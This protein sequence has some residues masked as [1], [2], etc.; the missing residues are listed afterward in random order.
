[1]PS[2]FGDLSVALRAVQ[3]HQVSI[4]TIEHNVSNANTVGYHRQEAVLTA[5][6]AYTPPTLRGQAT[7]GMIGGGV[8]VNNIKRFKME[9]FD[10][11]YRTELASS[12]RWAIR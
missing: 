2:L 11:R 9:F 12:K 6:L 10:N 3:A 4:E 8:V 7:A 1:M 5:G